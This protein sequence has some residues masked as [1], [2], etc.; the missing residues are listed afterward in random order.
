M[1]FLWLSLVAVQC[2]VSMKRR[3]VAIFEDAVDYRVVEDAYAARTRPVTSDQEVLIEYV[4]NVTTHEFHEAFYA[5][6]NIRD[7]GKEAYKNHTW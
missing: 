3:I 1:L 2:D 5:I 7:I 6:K 4:R